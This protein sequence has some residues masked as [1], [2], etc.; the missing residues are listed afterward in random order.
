[1]DSG[2]PG[3]RES[4]DRAA[5]DDPARWIRIDGPFLDQLAVA[6]LL[7]IVGRGISRNPQG[8]LGPFGAT[9]DRYGGRVFWDADLWMLPALLPLDPPRARR[10]ADYRLAGAPAARRWADVLAGNGLPRMRKNPPP[11]DRTRARAAGAIRYPWEGDAQGAEA[12]KTDSRFQEHITA[13]VVLGLRMARAHGLADPRLVDGISR[14]ASAWYR[15]RGEKTS[16]G[17]WE[18]KG[19]MSPDE[20]VNADNDVYT[21]MA[22]QAVGGPAFRLPRDARTFLAFDG[23]PLLGY[24][25]AAA[26][27]TLFP[28]QDQ[29]AIKEAIPLLERFQGKS[30]RNGPAMSVSLDAL[31]EA[32]HRDPDRALELW[33]ESWGRYSG[34]GLF[35][36]A[37]VGNQGVFLTGAAGCLNAIL[38]GF[39]NLDPM[40]PVASRPVRLPSSWRSVTLSPPQAK[41]RVFR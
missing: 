12:G 26:L 39:L 31:L 11:I 38:Y 22:A 17:G 33:R 37:P 28:L 36:E 30:T 4:V 18:L 1:L 20:S 9:N 23:D 27:L 15:L 25:Q 14:E 24:K 5:Q 3:F 2:Q 8:S 32:R 41:V 13:S 40:N 29:L 21:N 10:I 16:S 35:S 34:I 7:R 6:Q 19:V